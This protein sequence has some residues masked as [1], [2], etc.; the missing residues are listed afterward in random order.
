MDYFE[1]KESPKATL[2]ELIF[3]YRTNIDKMT[4][5]YTEHYQERGAIEKLEF[6]ERHRNIIDQAE[7]LL[8]QEGEIENATSV[9][10]I[11]QKEYDVFTFSIPEEYPC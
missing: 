7:M 2:C 3:F 8:R 9:L 1:E 4:E 10:K 6:L 5:Y 11:H